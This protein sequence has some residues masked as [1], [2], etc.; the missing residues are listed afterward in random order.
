[1][2][3]EPSGVEGNER[4]DAEAKRASQRAPEFIPIPY[5]NWYPELRKRTNELWTIQWRDENRDFFELKP[6][7]RKW[8]KIYKLSR[9]EEVVI[10]RLRLGHT[11]VTH[12]TSS[13][14]RMGSYI[15]R[16][17]VGVKQSYLALNIYY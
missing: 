10:N 16:C 17:V 11:R 2:G 13:N 7:T 15:N 6:T 12:D 3:S 4:A 1:M 14:M 9:K 5:S 8:A